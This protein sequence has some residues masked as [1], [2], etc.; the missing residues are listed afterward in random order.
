M[1]DKR[2]TIKWSKYAD[3]YDPIKIGSIDGKRHFVPFEFFF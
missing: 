3:K 1:C 2:N